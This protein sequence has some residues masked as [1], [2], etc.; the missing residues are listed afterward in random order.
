MPLARRARE[1]GWYTPTARPCTPHGPLFRCT[2][3][4]VE[5]VPARA[6]STIADLFGVS[7]LM[8]SQPSN[9]S[10]PASPLFPDQSLFIPLTCYCNPNNN[11]SYT[12]LT[13]TINNGDTFYQI[14]THHLQNLTSYQ[15]IEL[16]NPSLVPT[17]LNVGENVVLPIFCK[18]PNK[19]QLANQLNFFIFYVF[20]PSDNLSSIAAKFG[21]DI[22][23]IVDINGKSTSHFK[24]IYV[25]VSRLPQLVQPSVA[26]HLPSPASRSNKVIVGLGVSCFLL[27]FLILVMGV[28]IYRDF[29]KKSGKYRKD[30]RKKGF[31]TSMDDEILMADVSDCLDKYKV[32]GVQEVKE[33]TNG[34]A[35]GCLI[36]GSVYK[37]C[38]G[39]EFYAIKRMKWNAREELKILQKV[40]HGNLVRIQGFCIDPEDGNSYLVYEF[41]EN[42]SLHS[43]L[44]GDRKMKK[45]LDWKAR[46]KI[47]IDVANGLQYIHEHTRPRVV[48]KD[49]RT[50]NILLN[51]NMRAK[52]A[53]FGLAKSGCNAITTR[54]VGTQGYIAPEYLADGIVTTKMDVFAFGVVLLELVIGKEAVSDEGK[55]LWMNV[56]AVLEGKESEKYQR[57]KHWMDASLFDESCSIESVVNVMTVAIACLQRDP[58]RRPNMVDIVYT[59]CKSD[60][61]YFDFSGEDG[62]SVTHVSAR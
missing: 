21:S 33:A 43:W 28:W 19:I 46:L 9:L 57:M 20:Q 47:A 15:A 45:K 27:I 1:D 22:H 12:T 39:G 32:Y 42:G 62:L 29:M 52:I 6:V 50:S 41:V 23:S 14:S 26:P 56:S 11:L 59:L 58:S 5:S 2:P 13:Y 55:V 7:R 31:M 16:V 44:Y 30:E 51:R 48:H 24:T 34:F 49:I 36:Q 38:I 4:T 25:P 35:P 60:D 10:S 61:L 37:G 18:C 40:N 53:N 3:G 54:I 17:L 8:I